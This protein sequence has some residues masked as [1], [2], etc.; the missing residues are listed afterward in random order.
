MEIH[1]TTLFLVTFVQFIF[2]ALW[3]SPLLF[4]K[5]WMDSMGTTHVSPEERKKMQKSMMPFY[6]LQFAMTLGTNVILFLFMRLL[7]L[8]GALSLAGLIWIA[9][10][11]PT[12]ISGVIWGNTPKKKWLKQILIMISF[13]LLSLLFAGFIFGGKI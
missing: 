8:T 9:F 10:F 12:Q 5:Q 7:P 1:Y 4:G 3:Y 13:Q 6:I 2:G 11:V